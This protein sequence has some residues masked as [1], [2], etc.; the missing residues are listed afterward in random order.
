M[1]EG[2]RKLGWVRK[3]ISFLIFFIPRSSDC[4]KPFRGFLEIL[5]H[6][7]SYEF[8]SFSIFWPNQNPRNFF[9]K[10][11]RHSLFAA[12][13][14]KKLR[15]RTTYFLVLGHRWNLGLMKSKIIEVKSFYNYLTHYLPAHTE[16]SF[17]WDTLI[18]IYCTALYTFPSLGSVHHIIQ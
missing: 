2:K 14:N 12:L 15:M 7:I 10:F 6:K 8:T 3:F 4:K 17:F 1:T 9:Y 16:F 18:Y 5:I 11:Q 13:V